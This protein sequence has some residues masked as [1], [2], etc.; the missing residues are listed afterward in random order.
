[1]KRH[2]ILAV[3]FG[4]MLPALAAHAESLSAIFTNVAPATKLAIPRRAN[5]IFIQADSLGYGDLSC[6]GQTKFATP[7]L[8]ELAAGGIRF[9]NYSASGDANHAALVA[10]ALQQSGY[11]TGLI[12]EWSLGDETTANAPWNRGFDEFAGYFNPSDA[13]NYYADYIFRYAP[14][15]I[16][17]PTNN[18]IEDY[19]GREMLYPNTGGHQ[20]QYLPDIYTKAAIN[21]AVNNKPDFANHYQPFFLLVNY[22]TPR[23]NAVEA[24]RTG[25]GLQVPTDAPYSGEAWSQPQKNRAAMIARLD[26]DMGKLLEQLE[27]S[28]II[29]NT[30]VFFTSAST[31][32]AGGGVDPKF[33]SSNLASNDFRV[34][35]IVSWPGKIAT[36]QVSGVA[37]SVKDFGPTVLEIGYVKPPEKLEGKSLYPM[38]VKKK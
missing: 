1:M 14:K 15:N 28:G 4:L 20:G 5:I 8:D 32:K 38:L 16:L 6:Y 35:M 34:P 13:E 12:G 29:S 31:A 7:N 30:V 25:N 33:F 10:S 9:T 36:N 2:H 18:R 21:F 22:P 17:N 3:I 11:H 26:G 37:W 27:K 24:K 23:A 19:V